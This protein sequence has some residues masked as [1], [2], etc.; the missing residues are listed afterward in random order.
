[1][2]KK[3]FPKEIL[4]LSLCFILFCFSS[5]LLQQEVFA[6]Q[7][8]KKTIDDINAPWDKNIDK[9]DEEFSKI[10]QDSE[11]E[12]NEWEAKQEEAWNKHKKE[13]EDKWDSFV[14]STQK[15]WVDYSDDKESRS[16]VDFRDGFIEMEAVI[17]AD[18]KGAVE[19]AKKRIKE[20]TR[21]LFSDKNKAGE[22]LLENQVKDKSGKPVA[23]ANVEQFIKSEVLPKIKAEDKPYI[24]KDGVKRQKYKA[25]IALISEHLRIRAGRY[26]PIVQ[27]NAER[28]NVSPQL[29]MAV[30]HTE[31]YFNP[32]AVSHCGAIGLMQI[33]PRYAGCDAYKYI[34]DK[35]KILDSAYLY[36]PENNIELG[37][38]YLHLLKRKHFSSIPT[39]P[40]NRYL[41]VC[42]YNWGPGAMR[43]KILEKYN[44]GNMSDAD[45]FGLLRKKTP[46]ETSDYLK[47]VT[48]RMPLY[49][50]FFN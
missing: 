29:I 20:Q 8:V 3:Y 42:G 10:M 34:Y 12:W 47:R 18:K 48:E 43:K 44:V 38:A 25:R 41:T 22:K 40:K 45:L 28:F 7:T 30:V 2:K 23:D 21:K 37:A 26:L 16:S 49:S 36:K 6:D 35:E 15:D 5:Y 33:I 9:F 50:N 39:D 17:P 19:E 11:K 1:M 13:V 4:I 46:K 14:T 27:R 24:A 32:M 31:S